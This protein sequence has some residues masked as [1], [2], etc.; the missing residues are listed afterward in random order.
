MST[1]LASE[2]IKNYFQFYFDE[3]AHAIARYDTHTH[4]VWC[5]ITR[6]VAQQKNVVTLLR[7]REWIFGFVWK[8]W[9]LI[10]NKI[11]VHTKE[12]LA[13]KYSQLHTHAHTHTHHTRPH[14]CVQ[15]M[16]QTNAFFVHQLSSSV[17]GK[18]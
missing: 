1:R 4:T 11:G 3:N 13:R 17:Y 14:S 8:P 18:S 6:V 12:A 5:G 7:Q 9:K 15:V 16:R 10:I 2:L